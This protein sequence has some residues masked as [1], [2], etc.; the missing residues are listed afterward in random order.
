[1]KKEKL[2]WEGGGKNTYTAPEM[3][4]YEFSADTGIMQTSSTGE[5]NNLTDITFGW[6]DSDWTSIL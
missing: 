3:S 1:M 4:V 5:T 2:I 6:S